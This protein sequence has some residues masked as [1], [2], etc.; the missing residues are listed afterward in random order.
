MKSE[1]FVC[2]LFFEIFESVIFKKKG[3]NHECDT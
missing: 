3:N 2:S 1:E